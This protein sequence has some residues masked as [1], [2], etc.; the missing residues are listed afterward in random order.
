MYD[1]VTSTHRPMLQA[2]RYAV[3]SGHYLASLAGVRIL[4]RGGNAIDAGVAVGSCINVV[5]PDMTSFGGVAPIILYLAGTGEVVTISGLGRWPRRASLEYFRDQRGGRIP[6]DITNALVPSACDAWL[7]ALARYGRLPLAEVL[8]PALELAAEGF[9]VNRFLAHALR[10]FHGRLAGWPTSSAYLRQDGSPLEAGDLLRQPELASTFQA[11]IDA[12]SS[13]AKMGREAAIMAA[14]N[15]FYRGD[16]AEKMARFSRESGGFLDYEDL[17]GFSVGIEPPVKTGYRGYQVCACGPW[18][19]GPVLPQALNILE[20]FD[21]AGLEHN[22]GP[23]LH[24]LAES[25][26]ASFADRH[27][28]YGDPDFVRVPMAGLLSK[29]YARLW[30][31]RISGGRATPGMPEPGNPW[32]FEGTGG[33]MGPVAPQ[34]KPGPVGTDTSYCCVVDAEGNGFSATPSDGVGRSPVVPGVG[35]VLSPRG[36]QSW[37]DP[38]HPASLQ[39]GKRPR[40]TPSPALML[41]DGRLAM[42]FGTPGGDVQPQAMAQLVVNV[43][44]FGLDPQAAIE[45]PRV[46]TYSFPGS[47][48]AHNYNP[49]LLR[50]EGRISPETVDRLASLGHRVEMWPDYTS[51][52]GALCAILVGSRWGPRVAGADP[53][54]MA[55]AIGW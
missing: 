3:S 41:K 7:T 24:L 50:V 5:Q 31:G 38:R 19:Q 32:V 53:R 23:H 27:A 39:P 46:A 45:V 26:K 14:R 18:C 29:E 35:V 44:D 9:P 36:N 40:L 51:N 12:E 55:Y 15:R 2:S 47:F 4:E 17:A 42:V 16:L 11:L 33:S 37:L 34:P 49:G 22:S 25:L 10:S 52:A 28:Y 21:L 8:R 48:D 30:A 6:D 1:Y 20:C 43:V 13:A 54:R